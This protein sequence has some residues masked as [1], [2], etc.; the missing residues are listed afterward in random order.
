MNLKTQKIKQVTIVGL[1][2]NIFM[3]IL[4]VFFGYFGKSTSLVVDGVHSFSDILSDFAI[5]LGIKV[6]SKSP[7]KKH[8]YGHSRF[9]TF[10]T[11]FIAVMLLIITFGI[12][13][14][15]LRNYLTGAYQQPRAITLVIAF[16]SI[17]FKE[18]LYR[19]TKA[20]AAEVNSS[21]LLANAWHHRSDALSSLPVFLAILLS[22]I[23]PNW[24]FL[25]Y[26]GAIIVAIFLFL[27]VFK[28]LKNVYSELMEVSAPREHLDRVKA[29][30]NNNGEIRS[31]HCLR[32]R[33]VGSGL[34]FDLHIQVDK[35]LTVVKGH[36]IATVLKKE[37]L[38]NLKDVEDILI[39]IEPYDDTQHHNK[40][41]AID[42]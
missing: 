12:L 18:Y 5:I 26:I 11:I 2:V 28:L 15:A 41:G 6:W 19:K 16:F 17:I 35:N 39:H 23:N 36:E 37:I 30:I 7:D 9:E 3:A 32:S 24:R 20:V 25:D 22:I 29:I 40:Y 13:I 42:S 1:I 4:K 34:F 33:K 8:P 38:D 10:I 31:Y 14:S 21:A 27:F